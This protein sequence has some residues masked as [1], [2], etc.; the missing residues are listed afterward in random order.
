MRPNVLLLSQ[1]AGRLAVACEIALANAGP[2]AVAVGSETTPDGSIETAARDAY[3][4]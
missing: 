2:S 4:V 1:R 3:S